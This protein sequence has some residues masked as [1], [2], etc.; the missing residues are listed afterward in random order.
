[1]VGG[2]LG[3]HVAPP[4]GAVVVSTILLAVAGVLGWRLM[5][6]DPRLLRCASGLRESDDDVRARL[7]A[8]L[9]GADEGF[10]EWR[11]DT[12]ER[13][14]SQRVYELLGC[15]D[16]T[17]RAGPACWTDRIHPDDRGAFDVAVESRLTS[18]KPSCIEY[19]I[20]CEDG[21]YRW[22]RD[23]GGVVERSA[24]G[25]ALRASG[26]LTDITQERRRVLEIEMNRELLQRAESIARVGGWK[27]D[28]ASNQLSW[29]EQV[30]RIHELPM[31]YRPD[32]S[33]A[34][35]FYEPASRAKLERAMDAARN[36]GAPFDLELAFVTA[37][38]RPLWV[39]AMGE[40]HFEND[41]I[42]RLHGTF[43]DISERKRFE[44]ALQESQQRYQ[45]AVDSAADGI[46]DWRLPTDEV[47]HNASWLE[48]FGYE[49]DDI[50]SSFDDWMGLVHPDDVNHVRSVLQAYLD[51]KTPR[52]ESRHRM[53][54][55]SGDW[56]WILT[57]GKVVARDPAGRPVRITG[58]HRDVSFDK[59]VEEQLREAYRAAEAATR[60][61]TEFLANMSHEIRTPMT[62]ILGFSEH[63]LDGDVAEAERVRAVQTIR[64]NGEHLLDIINDILDLSKIEAGKLTIEKIPC[65]P[66]M[67]AFETKEL[68]RVRA[69][70]KQLT[71]T[72]EIDG[73]V[74]GRIESDPTRLRQVLV[75]IIGNA[76]KFTEVGGVRVV[77]RFLA[78]DEHPMI[79]FDVID[80]GIG[81]ADEEIPRLF[82]AFSQA[83][84]TMARRFGGTGL[85]L[86]ISRRLAE[87]LG[88]TISVRSERGKGSVFSI[89]IATGAID[90]VPF[91]D[92]PPTPP[93][94]EVFEAK[95]PDKEAPI[96]ARVLVAEDG[97]DNQRLIRLMLRRAG[98]TPV[99]A[100]NGEAAI[101]QVESGQDSGAEFDV[102]LMDMQM[103]VLDGYEATRRLRMS[104]FN[105]PIIAL[106]AHSMRGDRER[107][108]AAGC[109]D[110]LTKPIRRDELLSC[111]RRH[112]AAAA[113]VSMDAGI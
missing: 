78:D 93:E 53:R 41:R 108:M 85:G 36:E 72:L 89:T 99:I 57:R 21:D 50:A 40:P 18:N 58:T 23:R 44:I 80:T 28:I 49:T 22:F 12:G 101:L 30:F 10:W 27:L 94:F 81:I 16:E 106:T 77:M 54:T 37:K 111:I 69:E 104:G 6:G 102:I 13:W 7:E 59:E 86:V 100:D 105:K 33:V 63:L 1:M 20:R 112:L 17:S 9:S 98:V 26:S 48:L 61:K 47:V 76:I 91:V 34:L 42:V 56:K 43:Q 35:A 88:G 55:K 15:A 75:N 74:P 52:F 14:F 90:D 5:K 2:A 79:Q 11:I 4:I 66:V 19:R 71:L 29:S 92:A 62:A 110:Y 113:V 60:A 3:L 84:T 70:S 103:P 87:M 25:T 38:G 109:S 107:C 46:W 95:V 68:L 24:E 32:V 8:I 73:A 64:R 45:L 83:D 67:V 82:R 65:S 96:D 31:T 39:R 51:D 97:P